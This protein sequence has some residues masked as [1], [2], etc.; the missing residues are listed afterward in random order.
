MTQTF[1][2]GDIVQVL[3]GQGDSDQAGEVAS[4][5]RVQKLV[6]PAPQ[7]GGEVPPSVAL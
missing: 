5:E 2:R 3:P 4:E 1:Q 6:I 7:S